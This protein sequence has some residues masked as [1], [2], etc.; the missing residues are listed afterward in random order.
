MHACICMYLLASQ[1]LGIRGIAAKAPHWHFQK[2][3]RNGPKEDPVGER[4][5][6]N[7]GDREHW[8]SCALRL[9]R[10]NFYK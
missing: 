3:N 1:L 9:T 4:S 8:L 7:G 6:A 10:N 5:Q 2:E